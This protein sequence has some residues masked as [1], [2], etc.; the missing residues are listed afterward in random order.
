[1]KLGIYGAGGLGREVYDLALR[2][3]A[4]TPRWE[5]FFFVDDTITQETWLR[6]QPV[7][8]LAQARAACP[9]GAAELVVAVGD[10]ALRRILWDNAVGQ[11]YRMATLVSPEVRMSSGV[12]LGEGAIVHDVD[13]LSCDTRIGRNTALLP[14]SMVGH[15]TVIGDH[16]VLSLGATVCGRCSIGH[17]AYIAAGA[18]VKE[19]VSVGEDAVVAL[20]AVA[21]ADVP[22][23]CITMGNPARV[24]QRKT[25]PIFK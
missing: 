20:G 11:G 2:C 14:G 9:P 19:R 6:G 23:G 16:C 24:I 10:P 12:E 4:H 5:S 15:D 22:D 18:T 21:F 13:F 8:T 7:Y 17:G 1:M 25:G 3:D